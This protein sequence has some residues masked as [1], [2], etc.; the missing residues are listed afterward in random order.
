MTKSQK[1]YILKL[2]NEMR[3]QIALGKIHGYKPAAKMPT[4][5]RLNLIININHFH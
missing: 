3:N 1:E 2:H 5:V 4:F